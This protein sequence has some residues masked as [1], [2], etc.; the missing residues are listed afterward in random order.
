MLYVCM[1]NNY[2]LGIDGSFIYRVGP[3]SRC[4]CMRYEAKHSY[5]KS[6]AH[7]I[8]SFKNISKTM[9]NRHQTLMCYYLS[10]TYL[11]PILKEIKTP[12]CKPTVLLSI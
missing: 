6:I 5:F 7:R 9:A 1:H 8:R 3:L 12:K 10:N 11:S 4:W 2:S